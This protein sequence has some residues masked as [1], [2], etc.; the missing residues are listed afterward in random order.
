MSRKAGNVSKLYFDIRG[1]YEM[2]RAV[3]YYSDTIM[4]NGYWIHKASDKRGY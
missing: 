3:Y 1:Y 2:N 4:V